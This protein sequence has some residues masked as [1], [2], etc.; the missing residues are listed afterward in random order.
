[1][2]ENYF[3]LLIIFIGVKNPFLDT[4]KN[5]R[6]QEM[7]FLTPIILFECKRNLF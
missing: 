7:R 1:M 2:L 4:Y 3:L 5:D 6:C